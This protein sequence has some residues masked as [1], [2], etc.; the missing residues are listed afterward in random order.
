MVPCPIY[1]GKPLAVSGRRR[2]GRRGSHLPGQSQGADTIYMIVRRDRNAGLQDHA[3]T[4]MN[5]PKIEILWNHVVDEV[6]GDGIW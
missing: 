5:H 2:F 1:R 3:A 4:R 6:L